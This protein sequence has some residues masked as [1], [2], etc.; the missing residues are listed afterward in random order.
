MPVIAITGAGGFIGEALCSFFLEKNYPVLALNRSEL[1]RNEPGL[2]YIKYD[3]EKTTDF[4]ILEKADVVVHCA[5]MQWSEKNNN[6]DEININAARRLAQFCELNRKKFVFLSSFSAHAGAT[7]HYGR[8]KLL[9]ENELKEKHLVIKPGMVIG[10]RGLYANL[11]SIVSMR[12]VIP[13]FGDGK[14][15]LQWVGV[16]TLCQA[17]YN[18]IQKNL[19]G[20]FPV[21]SVQSTTYLGLLEAIA[22]ANGRSPYFIFVHPLIAALMLKA[23]AGKL[24][25]TKE[26]LDGL[27]QLKKF[28]TQEG[29]AE[30]EIEIGPVEE[31]V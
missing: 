8:H 9:L 7:S 24:P 28:D 11:R 20:I 27:M 16:R 29:L 12:K 30:L 31:L 21:A 15:P 6:A 17:I 22:R 1:K 10:K 14:Q 18:G 3:L 13:V 2:A 19:R 23:A 25:F 5:F 4:S 26:N